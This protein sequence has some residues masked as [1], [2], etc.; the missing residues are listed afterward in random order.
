MFPT[1]AAN[2]MPGRRLES[3]PAPFPL[4]SRMTT[5]PI[6][7]LRRLPQTVPFR[8]AK[9]PLMP[10]EDEALDNRP[11][12]N[13]YLKLRIIFRSCGPPVANRADTFGSDG[14]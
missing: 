4:S 2:S 6:S 11:S 1:A 7:R 14:K 13:H 9:E 10:A 5:I 8:R 12:Q 3:P